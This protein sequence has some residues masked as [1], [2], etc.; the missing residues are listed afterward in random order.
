MVLEKK[1]F[2][3]IDIWREKNQDAKNYTWWEKK[4]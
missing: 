1:S 4:A 3:L 2:D